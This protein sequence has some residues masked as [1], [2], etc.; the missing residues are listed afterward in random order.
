M[1]RIVQLMLLML[2]L[3]LASAP[4]AA[5]NFQPAYLQLTERDA[6]SY[7][8][9]WK[10][11]A[12]DEQTVLPI[13][14]IFPAGARYVVPLASSYSN[15][16]A[17]MIG[18]IAV[19][20]GLE[21]KVLRFE[22]LTENRGE[23][24]VRFIRND[25]SEKLSRVTIAEPQLTIAKEPDSIGVSARYTQLGIEHILLGFDHL[26]F[27]A[28]LVMLVAN[29]RKLVWTVTAFTVAHSI[30]LALVTLDVISV[31]RPPVEAFIA[32]SIVF[33]AVEIVRQKQG[34]PSL[35]SRKPWLVAFAFG[36]LHGFGFAGALAEIGL[37]QNNIPLAL[38]F[39][40]VGV[41]IGQLIFVAALLAL[42]AIARRMATPTQLGRASL[43]SC[44]A[45]GG[46]ASYW[47]FERIAA[48]A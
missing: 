25:G 18:R 35:A 26:L 4:A 22:G 15:G 23:V 48:F 5:D 19:P 2:W 37:P 9:R 1:A 33:V 12:V 7:D 21:G 20:G 10:T 34:M 27:V 45:I 41:E 11:L 47:L 6:T 42:A 46:I 39:F 14:P 8:V 36:L 32:L 38:L 24:L 29:F 40:N 43:V 44:Y 17:V 13:R 3:G 30:T 31:P 28:A 16:T